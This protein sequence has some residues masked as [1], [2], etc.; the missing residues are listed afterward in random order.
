MKC[1]YNLVDGKL[2][3]SGSHDHTLKIWD[4]D[5]G[6]VVKTLQGTLRRIC[7]TSCSSMFECNSI[8][9]IAINNISYSTSFYIPPHHFHH[10]SDHKDEI[11]SVAFSSDG[12]EIVF[13]SYDKTLKIIDVVSG[14]IVLICTGEDS[15]LFKVFFFLLIFLLV[16]FLNISINQTLDMT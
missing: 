2:L 8:H 15:Y 14:D 6:N 3:V 13:G 7:V 4:I 5:S 1:L 10:H 16:F 12:K 11:T 9:H